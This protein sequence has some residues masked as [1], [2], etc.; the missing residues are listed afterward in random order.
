MNKQQKEQIYDLVL[1]Y[2]ILQPDVQQDLFGDPV[3][4]TVTGVPIDVTIYHQYGKSIVCYSEKTFFGFNKPISNRWNALKI[5]SNWLFKG[6]SPKSVTVTWKEIYKT[7]T[8][9]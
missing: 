3:I 8:D 5:L 4:I 9:A 7:F 2:L 6:L 1:D